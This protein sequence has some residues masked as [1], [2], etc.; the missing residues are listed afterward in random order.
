MSMKGPSLPNSRRTT[1]PESE[2]RERFSALEGL[3]KSAFIGS[4]LGAVD[5]SERYKETYAD[6]LAA[7]YGG[8]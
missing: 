2:P 3:R 6:D 8:R 5:L 4:G 1:G 7:K